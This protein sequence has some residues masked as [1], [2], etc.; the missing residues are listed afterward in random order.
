MSSFVK[1][2]TPFPKLKTELPIDCAPR[3][4]NFTKSP[5]FYL[6][7]DNRK[8]IDFR[9][10]TYNTSLTMDMKMKE[11]K[12]NKPQHF[13]NFKNINARMELG[14]RIFMVLFLEKILNFK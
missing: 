6:L 11:K 7:R 12:N 13:Q 5:Y 10:I 1:H 2:L 9:T 4:A 3:Y 14:N 8:Y